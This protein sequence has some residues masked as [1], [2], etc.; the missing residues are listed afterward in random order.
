MRPSVEPDRNS[1]VVLELVQS[2]RVTTSLWLASRC[3]VSTGVPEARMSH[4][5][6]WPENNPPAIWVESLKLYSRQRVWYGGNSFCSGLF[7]CSGGNMQSVVVPR[8]CPMLQCAD[9]KWFPS[10]DQQMYVQDRFSSSPRICCT[11]ASLFSCFRRY[12]VISSSSRQQSISLGQPPS[13]CVM[14]VCTNRLCTVQTGVF[15]IHLVLCVPRSTGFCISYCL[16]SALLPTRVACT[17]FSSW[18]LVAC[19]ISFRSHITM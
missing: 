3:V 4:R 10:S 12:R 5:A 19:R 8:R 9:A 15:S 2:T 7:G 13:T 18:K 11:Y 1:F 14:P 16:A 6:T 17:S